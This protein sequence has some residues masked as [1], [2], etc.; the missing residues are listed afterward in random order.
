M[1][2]R[3]GKGELRAI[4]A[5]N[6][7]FDFP[8]HG[9]HGFDIRCEL[10]H[11]RSWAHAA[12]V[13]SYLGASDLVDIGN[14]GRAEGTGKHT[15]RHAVRSLR[16]SSK[17][18]GHSYYSCRV[19]VPIPIHPQKRVVPVSISRLAFAPLRSCAYR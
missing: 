18:H 17:P 2:G 7:A 15:A 1:Y 3:V 10:S 4:V 11:R 8:L 6:G 13:R 12:G 9:N 16:E 5:H 19:A 14:S